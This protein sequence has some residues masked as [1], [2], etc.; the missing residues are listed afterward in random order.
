MLSAMIKDHQARQAAKKEEQERRRKDAI[1]SANELTQN[2]VDHL[3]VGVAQAYL[4][5]KRLDAEA[6]QLH[7][8]ATNFAKQ[9]QQWL[10]LIENFN[11]SLKEIGDVENWA[12]TIENDMNV[13][14][15]ALEIAYKTSRE[16]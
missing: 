7:V 1:L 13:I 12:K 8:G 6:K 2:L 9:T 10:T 16:K 14:T 4:N 3:N 5:Q 15:T 11:G